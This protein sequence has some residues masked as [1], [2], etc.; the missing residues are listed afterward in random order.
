MF[1][2]NRKLFTSNVLICIAIALFVYFLLQTSLLH[3]LLLQLINLLLNI[4]FSKILG[5]SSFTPS[6]A[7]LLL[8]FC[9]LLICAYFWSYLQRPLERVGATA[10]L[11]VFLIPVTWHLFITYDILSISVLLVLGVTLCMTLEAARE[12]LRNRVNRKL[13]EEKHDAE[14][15]ILRHLNHNVK[16]NIQMA[17]SPVTAVISY[18]HS[19]NLLNEPLAKRLDGSVETVGEA[20]SNAMISLEHI[21]N[22]L[23]AAR[24][25]VIHEIKREDFEEIELCRLLREEIVPLYA[26]KLTITVDC[27]RAMPIRLHRQSFIEAMN[28]LIRNAETHGFQG[29]CTTAELLFQLTE[30]RKSVVIDYTNNGRPFPENLAEK[31]FLAF[32][33]KS[34]DSPGEGLGGAW[35]GKVIAAHNGSFEIIRDG[36]PLHFRIM[37]PKG[38]T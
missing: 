25:L 15:N 24:E 8:D 11:G 16:P 37:L 26:S 22:V 23:E 3:W 30:K 20:L 33:Q 27:A 4:H 31:D 1:L 34:G 29:D 12:F 10:A 9:V 36:H 19:K 32:G 6:L 7:S 35:I 13:T 5:K 2:P 17:K 21:N 14:Y 38:G 28:N 18:L